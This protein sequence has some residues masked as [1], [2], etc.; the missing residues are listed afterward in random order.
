M[1][2]RNKITDNQGAGF[3]LFYAVGNSLD[4]NTIS[5]NGNGIFVDRSQDNQFKNNKIRNSVGDGIFVNPFASGNVFTRNRIQAS[6]SYDIEDASIGDATYGTRNVY[7]GNQATTTN[8]P[9]LS[10]TKK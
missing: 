4:G 1:F 10:T 3:L 9:E 2:S 5:G 8:P 7:R 6:G